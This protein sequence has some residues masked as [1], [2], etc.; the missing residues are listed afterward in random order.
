MEYR[1]CDAIAEAADFLSLSS[2][3]N[4]Y[5]LYRSI[6]LFL[7]FASS[8]GKHVD[9]E[10]YFSAYCSNT[11]H[12]WNI[13]ENGIAVDLSCIE[14]MLQDSYLQSWTVVYF[15]Y[16]ICYNSYYVYTFYMCN[17]SIYCNYILGNHF[18]RMWIRTIM[19]AA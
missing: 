5:F 9:F 18:I 16:K 8:L 1:S 14:T 7:S 10:T 13:A 11:L 4:L 12:V 6:S 3:L 2:S 15:K 19:W 17:T